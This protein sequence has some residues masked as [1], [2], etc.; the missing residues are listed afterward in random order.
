MQRGRVRVG[1]ALLS[2]AAM[3]V[4]AGAPEALPELNEKVAAFA[5]ARLG[6][7]VGD[8]SCATLAIAAL[9]AA[10][11]KCYPS[12]EPD[13]VLI[14]GRPIDS[15]KEALPG[16]ILQFHNAVFQGKKWVT[17]RRWISWHQEYPQHTAIVSRVGEGGKLVT[18]LHQNVI[19]VDLD[20]DKSQDRS[21]VKDKS[22][23]KAKIQGKGSDAAAKNVQEREIRI[24]SLQG[25]WVRIYRPVVA[26]PRDRF[27]FPPSPDEEPGE[28]GRS[29]TD[30]GEGKG[31]GGNGPRP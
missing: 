22:R 6:Q 30:G 11:A 23:D 17:K 14:W 25:G 7:S 13:G 8:G 4:A 20:K 1:V 27:G 26:T 2:T 21:K 5:R 16:D 3:L 28:K 10:G 15:F 12:V 31:E 24:D 29:P 9:D 18:V 19:D